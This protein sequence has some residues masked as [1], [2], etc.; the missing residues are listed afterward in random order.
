MSLEALWGPR[1]PSVTSITPSHW[2]PWYLLHVRCCVKIC[3]NIIFCFSFPFCNNILGND[4]D[5]YFEK[6]KSEI[7]DEVYEEIRYEVRF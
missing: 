3:K 1:I 7:N 2:H 4:Q 5:V 6:S